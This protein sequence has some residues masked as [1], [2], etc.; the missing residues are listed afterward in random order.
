MTAATSSDTVCDERLYAGAQNGRLLTS[1]PAHKNENASLAFKLHLV[2]FSLIF[3]ACM[4]ILN[5]P[6]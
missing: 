2:V 5:V 1:G 3:H 6:H 4:L